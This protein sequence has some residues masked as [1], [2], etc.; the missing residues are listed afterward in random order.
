MFRAIPLFNHFWIK[1]TDKLQLDSEIF[2]QELPYWN[3]KNT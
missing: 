3:L 1:L 2:N